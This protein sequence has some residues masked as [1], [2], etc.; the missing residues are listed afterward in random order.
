MAKLKDITMQGSYLL[1]FH[2]LEKEEWLYKEQFCLT[3]PNPMMKFAN[4]I[5]DYTT[6]TINVNGQ[7]IIY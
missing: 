1:V 7:N 6:T 3:Q 5:I 4:H 2:Y